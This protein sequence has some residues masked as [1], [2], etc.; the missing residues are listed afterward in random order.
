MSHSR[1]SSRW[2]GSAAPRQTNKQ[3]ADA[4]LRGWG[5]LPPVLGQ[6]RDLKTLQQL[7][8]KDNL[9]PTKDKRAIELLRAAKIDMLEARRL[10]IEAQK[11]THIPDNALAEIQNKLRSIRSHSAPPGGV[12]KKRRSNKRRSNKRRSNKR[13][14][15]KYRA[16]K[17]MKG[18]ASK[19]RKKRKTKNKR[20]KKQRFTRKNIGPAAGNPFKKLTSYFANRHTHGRGPEGIG[21]ERHRGINNFNNLGVLDERQTKVVKMLRSQNSGDHHTT[22]YDDPDKRQQEMLMAAQTL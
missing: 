6:Q 18:G 2:F 21:L 22:L 20:M 10:L 14:S 7:L 9:N 15:N 8:S 19:N 12:T 4:I 16:K 13:R 17:M 3:K 5:L 1:S 11:P